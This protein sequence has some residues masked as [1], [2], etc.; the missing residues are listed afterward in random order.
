VSLKILFIRPAASSAF[1]LLPSSVSNLMKR[2]CATA[3]GFPPRFGP[4]ISHRGGGLGV[5]TVIS[6]AGSFVPAAR[7]PF[8]SGAFARFPAVTRLL[9]SVEMIRPLYSCRPLLRWFLPAFPFLLPVMTKLAG[10]C[11]FDFLLPFKS[12]LPVLDGNFVVDPFFPGRLLSSSE[13][14]SVRK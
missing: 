4:W 11:V 3:D 9:C 10:N 13:V 14:V 7:I 5:R 6:R 1:S 2:L 12:S 8:L